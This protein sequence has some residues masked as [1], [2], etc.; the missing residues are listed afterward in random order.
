MMSVCSLVLQSQ[1]EYSRIDADFYHPQ[2]LDELA[3]W[4]KIEGRFGVSKLSKLIGIPVR[5][6]RTPPSRKIRDGDEVVAFIKTDGVREG[7]VNF[8]TAGELP[9]RVLNKSDLIPPDSVVITIIGA[10]PEIVGRAAIIRASDPPCVT[11]QNVAVISTNSRCD[12]YYLTAFLQTKF[13]RDQVW[14]HSRRTEQVNLNCREVERI[15]V[16]LP[17]ADVQ[18]EIGNL[19]RGSFSASDQSDVTFQKAL[20]RLSVE[21]RL[22]TIDFEKSTAFS[23]RFTMPSLS[24]TLS[25]NR[26]DSQCFSP[27]AVFYK[28]L[29]SDGGRCDQLGTLLIS[30]AKGRQQAEKETGTIDYCSIKNLSRREIVKA[31]RASPGK[32]TP[33]AKSN[34]LLLAI[35]GATI[36]KIGIVKRY[37]ELAF[38][39]DML[40]LRTKD[41]IN[42]HYLL[43]VLD[44]HLGQVQFNR[45][46][47][48]ST[49]GHLAPRDVERVLV[50]RLAREEEDKIAVLVEESF[51]QKSDSEKLLEQAKAR[52][53]KLIEEAVAA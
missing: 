17:N 42:P 41:E 28:R 36:G 13:G 18:R 19:V 3:V 43:L 9:K 50:P 47:T 37:A 34:D 44:H 16:P 15:L 14:R 6:G 10:T 33:T 22:D 51:I 5:T 32:G 35:T 24:E 26:I 20:E 27:E 29:L 39:G 45:W 53:E 52:V 11:N 2:Y 40:R 21:L 48:G 25:A 23:S 31:S 7:T 38:S 12:P 46:I 30:V 1:I 49:N 8:N 4:K